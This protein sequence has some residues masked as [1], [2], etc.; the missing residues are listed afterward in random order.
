VPR[1]EISSSPPD[2]AFAAGAKNAIV[3]CLGIRRG[4]RLAIITHQG[5]PASIAAALLAA[6]RDAGAQVEAFV[7]EP[8]AATA[9]GFVAALLARVRDCDASLL[10]SS[11][12]GLPLE[13][14]RRIVEVGETKRRHGHMIGIT[15]AMMSQSM[16][17]DYA[18]V[19]RVSLW[20]ATRLA[21]GALVHASS[22]SGT[23]LEAR[24]DPVACVGVASGLLLDP[25]WTNLPGG[26][27][28][29]LPVRVQ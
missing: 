5:E 25:G 27:V 10:V 19:E 18:E 11:L 12:E 14:R 26:E 9:P 15:P 2:P 3:S 13:L 1:S 7:L 23:E 28:F 4:E 8:A 24:I 22:P 21:P 29:A 6:A 16:C 20:L 17:A